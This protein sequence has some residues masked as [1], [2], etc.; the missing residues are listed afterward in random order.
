MADFVTDTFSG[1]GSNVS[2]T[3]HVGETGATWTMAVGYSAVPLLL[4]ASSNLKGG[5]S[6]GS[7]AYASGVPA[8]AEYDI[9]ADIVPGTSAVGI[10][11]RVSTSTNTFYMASIS[12]DGATMRL[13][14]CLSGSY[15]ELGSYTISGSETLK[16]EIRDAAK[17]VY[18]GGVER[19]SSTD[20]SITDAGR[21]GIRFSGW[22]S[23]P[24]LDN[25][26]ATD[27]SQGSLLPNKL[28]Q[29]QA[30]DNLD[31]IQQHVLSIDPLNQSQSISNISLVQANILVV[32]NIDQTQSIENLSLTQANIISANDINQNQS[33]E[34]IDLILANFLS[35]SEIDQSQN[36][37][38]IDLIQQSE[39]VISDLSQIQTIDNIT[40]S[41]ATI[42]SIADIT[43]SQGIDQIN[44]I[45]QNTIP[46]GSIDQAQALEQITLDSGIIL[47]V[48]DIIQS[49]SIE[50]LNLT[51][52]SILE[53][54]KLL[55][56]QIIGNVILSIVG[57]RIFIELELTSNKID[58]E[59]KQSSIDLEINKEF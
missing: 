58:L 2:I 40:L 27:A 7:A 47:F 14:K 39:L 19:I 29:S 1:E 50:N 46:I 38:N 18:Y 15:T 24:Y 54:D 20:N 32:N 41:T 16:L 12:S 53:I 21:A 5:A 33:I 6:G 8:S 51:Q 34:N 26:K 52:E 9:E 30:I 45:Q 13:Y 23:P 3:S 10:I 36:I 31:L 57:G 28:N 44:L 59:L 25:F 56:G 17:K 48:A 11:G 35:I 43:Q 49:Q 22:N 4:S 42:L 37:D 55:Q